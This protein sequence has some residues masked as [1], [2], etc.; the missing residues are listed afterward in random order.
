MKI[1][2]TTCN[3]NQKWKNKTCQWECK[4]YRTCINNFSL[5]PSTCIA[6]TISI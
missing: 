5:N 2:N 1:H 6:R 4:S 3:L